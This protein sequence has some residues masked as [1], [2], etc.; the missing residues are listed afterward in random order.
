M[1]LLS[2][3][4]NVSDLD[5]SIEFYDDVLGLRLLFK[6]DQLAAIGGAEGAPTQVLVL[7]ALGTTGHVG[8]AHHIGARAIVWEVGSLDQLD[9]IAGALER[10]SSL[11]GKREAKTWTAVVGHDPDRIAIVASCSLRDGPITYDDWDPDELLYGLGE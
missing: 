4:L 2:V 6:G 1:N 5:Q 9:H 10:R 3:V 8:G 7:R 11:V